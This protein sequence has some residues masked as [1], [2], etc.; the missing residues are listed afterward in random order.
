MLYLLHTPPICHAVPVHRSPQT[1]LQPLWYLH[2]PSHP[3]TP[4]KPSN[5]DYMYLQVTVL[6]ALVVCPEM[7][8][9]GCS[10][11]CVRIMV[12][13]TKDANQCTHYLGAFERVETENDYRSPIDLDSRRVVAGSHGSPSRNGGN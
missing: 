5:T 13:T 4:P 8:V 1:A 3:V 11:F 10:V 2:V 7:R 6:A 12:R 9:F